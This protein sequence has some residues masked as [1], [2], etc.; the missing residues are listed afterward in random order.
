MV[1]TTRD[2]RRRPLIELGMEEL[3]NGVGPHGSHG[4]ERPEG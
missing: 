4:E 3:S 2:L 1:A